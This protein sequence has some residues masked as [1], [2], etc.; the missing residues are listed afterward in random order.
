MIT[1]A[2]A[3]RP[4]A[5]LHVDRNFFGV[6][7]DPWTSFILPRSPSSALLPFL[8]GSP[9]Y[10]GLQKQVGILIPTSLLEDP[11]TARYCNLPWF[12]WAWFIC[13]KIA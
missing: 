1:P 13:G 11:G 10:N 2:P 4:L 6:Q 9:Y 12:C 5:L 7:K 3:A 8:G